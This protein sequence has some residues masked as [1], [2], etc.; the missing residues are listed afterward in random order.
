MSKSY[1]N[2]LDI[3]DEIPVLDKKIR[4]MMTD[5]ARERRT[6]PGE[7]DKCPVW[8]LHKFFNPD[9]PKMEEIAS[10]C[11]TASIGC[12][13]CKKNLIAH[14]TEHMTPIQERRRYFEARGNELDDILADGAR[15][16]GE[17]AGRTMSEVYSALSMPKKRG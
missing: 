17:T 10:G 14:V 2:S 13:D 16:A 7:P 9:K 1:G 11:R 12:V 15:R 4:T 5:P 8:D 6:D 3:A